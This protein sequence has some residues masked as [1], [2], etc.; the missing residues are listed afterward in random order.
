MSADAY[1]ETFETHKLPL[2]SP[3]EYET[4]YALNV[5]PVTGD[6]WITSNMSDR[7]FRFSPTTKTF[8]S[9]LLPTRVTWLRDLV[10]AKDGGD[11]LELVQP[12]GLRHRGRPRL[13]HLPLS[14][15]RNR[16]ELR[17]ERTPMQTAIMYVVITLLGAEAERLPMTTRRNSRRAVARGRGGVCVRLHGGGRG[18]AAFFPRGRE[19]GF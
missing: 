16:R 5:H 8:V 9:H 2:L 6:V 10:F 17:L 19:T 13:L 15:G 1:T 18:R 14:R 4:P 3:D 12:A 7:I 11:L